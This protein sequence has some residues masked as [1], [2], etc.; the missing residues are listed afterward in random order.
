[1]H[2][3]SHT[4]SF[5]VWHIVLRYCFCSQTYICHDMLTCSHAYWFTCY[6]DHM[7]TSSYVMC[8]V[9]MVFLSSVENVSYA[10]L[11]HT[12]TSIKLTPAFAEL[13]F[14]SLS[15]CRYGLGVVEIGP[16]YCP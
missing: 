6:H 12:H 4:C 1:M 2:V 5:T 7:L 14:G 9:S 15:K 3:Y 13:W 10:C 8:T 11:P 16:S